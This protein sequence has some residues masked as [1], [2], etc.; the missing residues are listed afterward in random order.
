M[1]T[2]EEKE[3]ALKILNYK[4]EWSAAELRSAKLYNLNDIVKVLS[5][6]IESYNIAIYYIRL[7]MKDNVIV[8]E[9][10]EKRTVTKYLCPECQTEVWESVCP[11]C[12]KFL[13]YPFDE[14]EVKNE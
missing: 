5:E 13:K 10:E 6:A 2:Q 14:E 7:S 12:G 3:K 9:T 1:Y 11:A 4:I 8:K